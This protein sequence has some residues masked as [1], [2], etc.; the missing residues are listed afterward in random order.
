MTSGI[1]PHITPKRGVSI[2]ISNELLDED[3]SSFEDTFFKGPAEPLD[4]VFKGP[5]EPLRPVLE[6]TAKPLEVVLEGSAEPLTVS[7]L[8]AGS[9]G[10]RASADAGLDLPEEA[11]VPADTDPGPPEERTEDR[12]VLSGRSEKTHVSDVWHSTVFIS[13]LVEAAAA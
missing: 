4:A 7:E 8:F 12:A 2:K 13:F 9:H 5:A 10:T 6:G 11:W 1:L 3:E